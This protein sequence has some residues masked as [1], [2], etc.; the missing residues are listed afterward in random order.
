MARA[1]LLESG[2]ASRVGGQRSSDLAQGYAA[3]GEAGRQDGPPRT[4]AATAGSGAA[5]DDSQARARGHWSES[6]VMSA[7]PNT[8][9]A[10][11]ALGTGRCLVIGEVAL[12]HDGSLGLAHAFI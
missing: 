4:E 8:H 2:E 1:H 10:L 9:P 11:A 6:T 12:T 3:P 7:P 5:E